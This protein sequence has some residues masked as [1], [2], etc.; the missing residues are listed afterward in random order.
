MLTK[1]ENFI[2]HDALNVVTISLKMYV[3]KQNPWH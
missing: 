1:D 3:M 2:L